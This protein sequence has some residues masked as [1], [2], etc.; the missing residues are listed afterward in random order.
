MI[1]DK[2]VKGNTGRVLGALKVLGIALPVAFLIAIGVSGGMW[3]HLGILLATFGIFAA[4][5]TMRRGERPGGRV[6][7]LGRFVDSVEDLDEVA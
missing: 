1:E 4:T 3:V 5:V 7:S 2:M 6:I